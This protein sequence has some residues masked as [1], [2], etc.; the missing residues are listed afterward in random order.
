[1][2]VRLVCDLA[3]S[4]RSERGFSEGLVIITLISNVIA[5]HMQQAE[6]DY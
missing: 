2:S 4:E 3:R 5:R 1:M 6:T